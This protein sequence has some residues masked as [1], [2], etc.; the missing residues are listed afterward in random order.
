M[1]LRQATWNLLAFSYRIFF[2]ILSPIFLTSLVFIAISARFIKGFSSRPVRKVVWGIEPLISYK[3][4]SSAIK[5]IGFESET[6][7]SH[8]NSISSKS[9][10]DIVIEQFGAVT[11]SPALIRSFAFHICY[12]YIF[13][14]ILV[15]KDIAAFSCTGLVLNHIKLGVINYKVESYLLKLAKVHTVVIPYGGDSYVFRNLKNYDWLRGLLIS[16]PEQALKQDE[17]EARVKYWVK[18]A[19]TFVP[20]TSMIFDG[21]GRFD[22]VHP[23]LISIDTNQWKPT[24]PQ[25]P[26]NPDRVTIGHSPNH[27]GVKGTEFVISAVENLIKKGLPVDLVLIEG[28][29]NGEVL[30]LMQ[31]VIDIHVDQL[32]ADGYALNAIEAMSCGLVVVGGF[33]GPT[34]DFFDTWSVTKDC[35]IVHAS[36]KTLESVLENLVLDV[37][38]RTAIGHSGRDYVLANHSMDSFAKIFL[39]LIDG[40][41]HKLSSN[42]K[43]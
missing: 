12:L 31:T 40:D 14:K 39:N 21:F 2:S 15:T 27:R 7:V 9:D 4:W 38:T 36:P 32:F 33:G 29:S 1:N 35:P 43:F 42:L 30:H 26:K 3:Y 13:A 28:A 5:Q 8:V 6:I 41:L 23:N 17:I 10:Y 22:Y 16:Y 20:L 24:V 37:H 11:K 18:N 19:D 34:R 25:G